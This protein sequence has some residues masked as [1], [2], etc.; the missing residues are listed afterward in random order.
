[1]SKAK[2]VLGKLGEKL[3]VDFLQSQG[4]RIWHKNYR[5]KLGEVD[6]IAQ[7]KDTV[8][9]IEVKTRSSESKGTA[10]EAISARKQRAMAKAALVFLKDKNLL[11]RR[12]RFDV[13]SIMYTDGEPCV[14][15]LKDA[16]ELDSSF[17]Y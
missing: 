5:T 15:I 8:S 14:E 1:M 7:D 11:D 12:A 10:Q 17:T 16:F 6:I 9:F 3:A 2:I 4:Y 13:V